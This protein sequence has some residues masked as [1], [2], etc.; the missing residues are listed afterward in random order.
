MT[1]QAVQ[2]GR[3]FV[4]TTQKGN[5]GDSPNS[6]HRLAR[7]LNGRGITETGGRKTN[8]QR[9]NFTLMTPFIIRF[10][11]R[12]SSLVRRFCQLIGLSISMRT[13]LARRIRRVIAPQAQTFPQ[14][15]IS[16]ANNAGSPVGAAGTA[17]ASPGIVLRRPGLA[18]QHQYSSA[19]KQ[20]STLNSDPPPRKDL[21]EWKTNKQKT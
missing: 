11:I 17:E 9:R 14:G 15:P 20:C 10:L 8:L 4:H 3:I 2:Q 16:F 7:S 5:R 19:L 1:L 6:S 18:E 21:S 12:K 13:V